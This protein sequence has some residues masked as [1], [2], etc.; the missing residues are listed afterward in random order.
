M[1]NKYPLPLLD[2]AFSPFQKARFF[3]KPNLRNAYHLIPD[4]A[5]G[6][7]RKQPSTHPLDTL[8]V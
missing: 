8:S 2:T 4:L 6:I 7:S 5:G 1:M 3:T